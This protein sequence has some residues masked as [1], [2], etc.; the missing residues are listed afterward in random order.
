MT[1]LCFSYSLKFEFIEN[2]YTFYLSNF[3]FYNFIKYTRT[4]TDFQLSIH[5]Y[6]LICAW[7][8]QKKYIE[9]RDK[10]K[11]IDQILGEQL[12]AKHM[13]NLENKTQ[14]CMLGKRQ[15]ASEA[16]RFKPSKIEIT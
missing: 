1:L 6:L 13:L 10:M 8:F 5:I 3:I 9:R 7:R 4:H 15:K 11:N 14:M 12:P 16:K 2:N